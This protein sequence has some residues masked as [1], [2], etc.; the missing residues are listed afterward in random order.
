MTNQKPALGKTLDLY[1]ES[2]ITTRGRCV[3]EQAVD[4]CEVQKGQR[5]EHKNS[6]AEQRHSFV[7]YV[8]SIQFAIDDLQFS[9]R[10]ISRKKKVNRIHQV[11]IWIA[12]AKGPVHTHKHVIMR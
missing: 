5:A 7:N 6:R 3:A 11:L 10:H 12:K 1:S 8:E 4:Q 2:L 9:S